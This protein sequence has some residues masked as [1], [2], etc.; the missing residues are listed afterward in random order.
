ML[1][2]ERINKVQERMR[3]QSI[4]AYMILTHDDYIYLMGEDRYQPRA[5]IPASGDP[6]IITFQGK[7]RKCEK[8]SIWKV[9]EFLVQ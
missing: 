3:A 4:D 9:S 7:K 8:I 6:I 1:H 5:I 2:R